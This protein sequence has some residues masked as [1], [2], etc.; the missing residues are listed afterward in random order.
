VT[1]AAVWAGC[2]ASFRAILSEN[3][4]WRPIFTIGPSVRSPNPLLKFLCKPDPSGQPTDRPPPICE[5]S[6]H[7]FIVTSIFPERTEKFPACFAI[8]LA[9]VLFRRLANWNALPLL[10]SQ[11]CRSSNIA[12]RLA[13]PTHRTHPECFATAIR[14]LFAGLK[15]HTYWPRGQESLGHLIFC[16]QFAKE[17]LGR[18]DR[19]LVAITSVRPG[20]LFATGVG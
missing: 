18:F 12:S 17:I 19:S 4:Q 13:P 6:L 16:I 14:R 11:T 1:S 3:N 2:G 5:L 15:S 9:I 8:S 10:S 7:T 20:T